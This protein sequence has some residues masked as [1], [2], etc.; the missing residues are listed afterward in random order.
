MRRVLHFATLTFIL[1]LLACASSPSQTVMIGVR[2]ANDHSPFYIAE[3]LGFY[4]EEK[5]QVKVVLVP[6]NTEIIEGLK[7]GEF[8]MGAVPV[9]TAIAAIAQ[10]VP[11][12]IVAMTGRGSDGILVRADSNINSLADLRGKR[13]A[14]IRASILD[15]LLLMALEK[16]GL[17][18]QKDVEIIYFSTLG[19]MINALKTGQV[20]AT[21]NTEPFMT[22][23]ESAG[24]GKILLYFTAYWK[25]HPCCVV[26]ARTDFAQRHPDLVRKI[27]KAHI[28]AVRYA[29]EHPRETAE[30]IVE[31][32]KAFNPDLVEKSLSPE[33][34]LISC[35]IEPGEIGRM[36]ELMHRYGFTERPLTE[37]E[38]VNLEFLRKALGK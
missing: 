37:E 3:K 23:A 16:A 2:T 20:D 14:T 35:E 5:V 26:I 38:L 31:Y 1:L 27:L 32:L 19:D 18:P 21:A 24:W 15:V 17:D 30:I 8:Q 28:R 29:N 36:A 13:I 22:E 34:M 10:G 12:R 4:N 9:T 33:K 7:R 25:D 6:S 11:I